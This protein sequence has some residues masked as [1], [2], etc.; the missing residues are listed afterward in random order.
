MDA[1]RSLSLVPRIETVLSSANVV[2][3]GV[4]GIST[5]SSEGAVIKSG[6]NGSDPTSSNNL[7][8]DIDTGTTSG[9]TA[10]GVS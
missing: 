1:L 4:N 8:R 2:L 5:E 3:N 7:G 9:D 10:A 6:L